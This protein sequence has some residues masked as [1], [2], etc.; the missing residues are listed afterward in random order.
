M[1]PKANHGKAGKSMTDRL[2]ASLF[3]LG[4]SSSSSRVD[5][6]CQKL[7]NQKIPPELASYIKRELRHLLC[8]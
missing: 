8:K 7:K 4:M 5:R 2:V 1:V 3:Y 6:I